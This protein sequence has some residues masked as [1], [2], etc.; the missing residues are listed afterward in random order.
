MAALDHRRRA[1]VVDLVGLS[2]LLLVLLDYLRPA[3]LFLPTVT[4]G[5]DTPCHYPTLVYLH[6][7]LLPRLRLQGWYPGAYLG[8]PLLLYYFPLAF[9]VMSAL[10]SAVGVVV[11]QA[12]IQVLVNAAPGGAFP[13]LEQTR[14][15][16][17]VPPAF[18]LEQPSL[19]RE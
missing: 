5:G 15:D 8:H 1:L 12:L 11:A 6:D 9:L 3:L 7:T 2:V 16:A 4:A 13:R 18:K 17:V 10:A 14:V 19:N